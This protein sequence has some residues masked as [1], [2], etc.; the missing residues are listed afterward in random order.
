MT[1]RSELEQAK[2]HFAN[3]LMNQVGVEWC[4]CCETVERFCVRHDPR[5]QG[6]LISAIYRAAH[7]YEDM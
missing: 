2:R 5:K 7:R 4:E 1:R 3:A 6:D